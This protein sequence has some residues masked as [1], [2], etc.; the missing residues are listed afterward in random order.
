MFDLALGETDVPSAAIPATTAARLRDLATTAHRL[1]YAC[2]AIEYSTSLPLRPKDACRL[3][4]LFSSA[5]LGGSSAL[6]LAA[7]ATVCIARRGGGDAGLAA[8]PR[9]WL[10]ENLAQA[11]VRGPSWT[12]GYLRGGEHA[13]V[14]DQLFT[15]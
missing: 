15:Q 8:E 13:S 7:A 10:H 1:G 11:L 14:G 6:D 5:S 2:G 9:A 4:V 3:P 12:A